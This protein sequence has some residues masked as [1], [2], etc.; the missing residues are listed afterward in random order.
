MTSNSGGMTS[1]PAS[2]PPAEVVALRGAGAAKASCS[3]AR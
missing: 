1:S 2:V 3:S